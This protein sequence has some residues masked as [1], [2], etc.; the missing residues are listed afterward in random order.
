MTL[1]V[2]ANLGWA[3]GATVAPVP[4]ADDIDVARILEQ[5]TIARC[6]VAKSDTD[7]ARVL[8]QDTETGRI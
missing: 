6:A 5:D 4:L 8:V 1:L 7:S 2:Q 3:W